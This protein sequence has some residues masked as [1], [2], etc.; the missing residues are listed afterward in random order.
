MNIKQFP[1][2]ETIERIAAVYPT[3]FHLYSEK[4]LRTRARKLYEAF[5]WNKGFKEYYAVKACPTPG[6]IRILQQEGCGVDCASYCELKIAEAMGFRGEEI[7]FSSNETP[8]GEFA[9]AKKLGAIINLDD[10]TMIDSLLDECGMPDK[11]CLRFNPGGEFR[12]GNFVMGNPGESKFG[13][14]KEQIFTA[15]EK[16][17]RHGAKEIALHAFLASNTTDAGYYPANAAMLMQLALELINET[18]CRIFMIN[19]SGGIG[20]PYRP[21]ENEADINEIGSRVEKEYETLMKA[22]GF[23]HVR[24]AGELGR[25]MSGPAGWLITRAIHEKDIYR[26]YIGVDACAA[27]LMRP[28]MYGAYHHITV[29]G[30][31]NEPETELYDVVGSLCENNDKFAVNRLLP[32]VEIGDY[33]VIHDTGA[34]GRSM[35]YNYNGRLRCAEVMLKEDGSL[36]LIRRAET[37]ND[38]FATLDICTDIKLFES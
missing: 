31:E 35:G 6:V 36:E 16:C 38:Y 24:L 27:D 21:D 11:I 13:M 15:A 17:L 22:N 29:A 3:P 5:S 32:K 28:A 1:C 12:L 30:K 19:L 9:Y 8:S 7:M 25:Y 37:P 26:H 33:L 14:T 4:D 34:H 2:K 20:I 10:I 18:G 23:E